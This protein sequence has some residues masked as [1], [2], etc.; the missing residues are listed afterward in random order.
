MTYINYLCTRYPEYNLFTLKRLIPIEICPSLRNDGHIAFY[1]MPLF[2]ASFVECFSIECCVVQVLLIVA[3]KN[4]C[5]R[6]IAVGA[7]V[8]I[9]VRLAVEH[10]VDAFD[11]CH[12]DWARRQSD[13]CIGVVGALNAE[14]V[15]VDALQVE[16]FQGKLHRGIGLQ[17]HTGLQSVQ[18]HP[19]Y[20]WIFRCVCR[21]LVLLH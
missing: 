19:C 11:A 7:H 8:Q 5:A 20:H 4:V 2:D 10:R 13:V 3:G 6:K 21:F 12:F 9:V 14:M 1:T 17:G 16:V 15:V 18:V